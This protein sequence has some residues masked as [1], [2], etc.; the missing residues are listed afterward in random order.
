MLFALVTCTFA[1]PTWIKVGCWIVFD[2]V[3][4]VRISTIFVYT[5]LFIE[6]FRGGFCVTI[7]ALGFRCDMNL[8]SVVM[9]SFTDLDLITD[10]VEVR[11]AR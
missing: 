9:R 11:W 10:S 2:N 6:F 8:T 5:S 3:E 7:G 4:R 1:G